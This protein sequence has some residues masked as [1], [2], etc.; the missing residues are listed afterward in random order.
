MD[1]NPEV[2]GHVQ[3]QQTVQ[4]GVVVLGG[5]N[6]DLSRSAVA[7]PIAPAPM[8]SADAERAAGVTPY[9]P[10]HRMPERA[11]DLKILFGS[12]S[13]SLKAAEQAKLKALPKNVTIVVAGH[14]DPDE[15]NPKTL[16]KQR[17]AAVA[18][19]LARQGKKPEAAKSFG[20]DLPVGQSALL[21]PDN[22]RVEVFVARR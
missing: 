1:F 10:S 2:P 19:Y 22:R 20:A 21:A 15:K 13:A 3:Y 7:T 12:N 14:A 5:S 9:A 8:S 6:W 11:P 17:A 4:N 16:A 18:S